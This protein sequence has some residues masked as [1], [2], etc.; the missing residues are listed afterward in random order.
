MYISFETWALVSSRKSNIPFHNH[1]R[2]YIAGIITA[3]IGVFLLLVHCCCCIKCC[4]Q[5]DDRRREKLAPANKKKTKKNLNVTI[6][7][8]QNVTMDLSGLSV[9]EISPDRKRKGTPKGI[10]EKILEDSE[11]SSEREVNLEISAGVGIELQ[12]VSKSD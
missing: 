5:C 9:S 8:T 4:E 7:E 11:L 6:D 3:I 2:R 12:N 10:Q 1:Y